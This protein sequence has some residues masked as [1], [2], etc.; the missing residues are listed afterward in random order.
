MTHN[1]SLWVTFKLYIEEYQPMYNMHLCY[2]SNIVYKLKLFHI[3]HH[4]LHIYYVKV[5]F[6]LFKILFH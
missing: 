5:K 6:K 2:L 1:H 3:S 4:S